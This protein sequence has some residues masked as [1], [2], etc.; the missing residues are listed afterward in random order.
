[1]PLRRALPVTSAALMRASSLRGISSGVP[2]EA[3]GFLAMSR[4]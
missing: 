2:R 1:L 4:L 3:V